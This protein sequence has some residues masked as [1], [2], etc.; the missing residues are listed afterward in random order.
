MSEYIA[1]TTIN[2]FRLDK[3]V[4]EIDKEISRIAAQRMIEE[5][6]VLV[7]GKKAKASYRVCIG[8]TILINKPEVKEAKLKA[9][10]IPLNILYEDDDI[11]VVNKAKGMVVHPA[12]RKSRWN[13]C[14]CNNESL[15]RLIIRNWWRNKT[16]NS[17]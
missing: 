1:E 7:N 16:G 6:Y 15:P 17:T 12:A 9:Q 2:N 10:D 3:A 5:G 13:T 8:D 14:K 11:I 4:V